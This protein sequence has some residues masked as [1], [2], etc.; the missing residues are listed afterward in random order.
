MTPFEMTASKLESS[1]GQFLDVGLDELDLRE[2]LA[3]PKPCRLVELLAG[4]VDAD[5]ATRLPH[6]ARRAERVGA[7]SRA[8]VEDGFAGLERGEVEVMPDPGERRQRFGRDRVQELGGVAEL[9]GQ[10]SS[11][12]EVKRRMLSAGDMPIHVLDR[13]LQS[14]PS[15]S[16]LA[17][18]W[19][20]A[21]ASDVSSGVARVLTVIGAPGGRR[22]SGRR[23]QRLTV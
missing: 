23:F 2:S 7:R 6:Q 1:N 14:R 5:D 17:S 10:A 15:T 13:R 20:N 18:S 12:L 8:E 3:V 11:H 21:S 16:E 9:F 4:D 19:G 22:A